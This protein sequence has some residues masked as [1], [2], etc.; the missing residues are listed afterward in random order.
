MLL[1]AGRLR[2]GG[3]RD[4]LWRGGVS[5]H[6]FFYLARIIHGTAGCDGR[7]ELFGLRNVTCNASCGA[8]WAGIIP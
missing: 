1:G 8:N 5:M 6:F 7:G 4:V 3:I 2:G